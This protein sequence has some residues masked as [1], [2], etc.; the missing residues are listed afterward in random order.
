MKYSDYISFRAI[1]PQTAL[2]RVSRAPGKLF[3][4]FQNRF[5]RKSQNTIAKNRRRNSVS[6]DG[7]N[8]HLSCC[9]WIFVPALDWSRVLLNFG[10]SEFNQDERF[11]LKANRSHQ[12]RCVVPFVNR[13]LKKGTLYSITGYFFTLSVWSFQNIQSKQI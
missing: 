10:R 5:I 2:V 13:P 11:L 9:H 6:W 12:K 3:E 7:N 8:Q 4:R 1:S